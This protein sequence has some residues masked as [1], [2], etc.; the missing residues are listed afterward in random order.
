MELGAKLGIEV[1]DKLPDPVLPS[2]RESS[3]SLSA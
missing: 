2:N 3:S 1:G